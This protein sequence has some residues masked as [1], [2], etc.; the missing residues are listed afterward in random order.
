MQPYARIRPESN[1]LIK[2]DLLSPDKRC[3]TTNED[4]I[5]LDP[6]FSTLVRMHRSQ[7]LFL[8]VRTVGV[9]CARGAVV[10]VGDADSMWETFL[11]HVPSHV[12]S[13]S[14]VCL[15]VCNRTHCL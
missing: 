4:F 12:Q 8:I 6:R 5:H 11:F 7:S 9:C 13:S 1:G 14:S 10:S 2:A 3:N 15:I